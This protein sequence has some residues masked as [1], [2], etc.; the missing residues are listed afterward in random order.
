M[1]SPANRTALRAEE[2]RPSRP[3]SRSSPARSPA[4]PRTAA[5]PAPWRRSGAGPRSAAGAA[6]GA[7][8][9]P[10]PRAPP[11]RQRPAAARPGTDARQRPR[12]A[13]P[14]LSRC[15]AR[16]HLVRAHPGGRTPRGSAAPRR[17]ARR[18]GRDRS[19]AAPGIPGCATAG[20]STPAA[21]P[22]PAAPAGAASRSC[23]SWRAACGPGRT[24]FSRLGDVRRDAGRGQLL[25]DVP[26]AGAPLQRKRDV[27]P[28]GEPRQPGPQVRPVGRGD[29]AALHLPGLGIEVVERELLP[30]D[31]QPAYDGHRDLLKLQRGLSTPR[32]CLRSQS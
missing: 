28:A 18:A 25:R 15:A 21:G 5:P 32:E 14:D 23:R 9:P 4:R 7:S 31:I 29:L 1:S 8:G 2:N 11:A 27:V 26:P 12:A 22:R 19:P 3:A 6:P 13:R 16:R 17:C 20:S 10:A 24:R 30:V